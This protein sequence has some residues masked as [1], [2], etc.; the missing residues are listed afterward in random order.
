MDLSAL[1]EEL[2]AGHGMIRSSHLERRASAFRRGINAVKLCGSKTRT[3]QRQTCVEIRLVAAHARVV[4]TDA[5]LVR[6][7]P[8]FD[9]RE[10][11]PTLMLLDAEMPGMSGFQ[12]CEAM[13]ADATL[14]DVAV[15][16]VT[17]HNEPAFIANPFTPQLVLARVRA[18]LRVKHMAD[19]LHRI[20]TSDIQATSRTRQVGRRNR[21]R[22][23]H[24]QE[25]RRTHGRNG[26]GR[27]RA[28]RPDDH[29]VLGRL[30][31]REHTVTLA[32]RAE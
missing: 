7:R 12:V 14:S 28:R 27:I 16:F 25:A 13:K 20:A 18:Q 9:G 24:R 32:E 10:S 30:R 23:N 2:P 8:R 17:K 22:T 11:P 6:R 5:P 31:D 4:C 3:P 29:V 26:L 15:I 19:E 21:R 1:F